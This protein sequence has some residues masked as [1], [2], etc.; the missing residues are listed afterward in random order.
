[1]TKQ[2]AKKGKYQTGKTETKAN[3]ETQRGG[4][5][6][7]SIIIQGEESKPTQSCQ[8]CPQRGEAGPSA[9]WDTGR[10]P[11]RDAQEKV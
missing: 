2:G 6:Y 7:H 11:Q 1:M 3:R 9:S 4:N 5:Y 8:W 10:M